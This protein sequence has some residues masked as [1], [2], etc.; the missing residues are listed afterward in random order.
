LCFA[1]CSGVIV[2]AKGTRW[3]GLWQGVWPNVQVLVFAW[4]VSQR[5]IR[6]AVGSSR[7]VLEEIRV[8][9]AAVL[10]EIRVGVAAV[11]EELCVSV[12]CV[13]SAGCLSATN[14]APVAVHHT[15][16]ARD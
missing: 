8:G 16:P 15:V 3:L 11:L 13:T 2:V 5:A 4:C 6:P 7:A 12:Y 14:S 10:E 9:V 1:Q